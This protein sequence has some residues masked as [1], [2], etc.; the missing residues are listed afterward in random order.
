M[1][2]LVA[3]GASGKAASMQA[4]VDGLGARGVAASA[5]DLPLR[6]AEKAVP[7]YRERAADS[8]VAAADLVI[9]GQSYG[10]RVASL[11]AAEPPAVC[12]GLIC[13]SYPL[14]RPGQPDWDERSAHWPDIQVPLLFLSGASDP[15]A[16]LDLLQ[17]AIRERRPDA[18]LVTYPGVG[19]SLKSVLD[20]A[21]DAAAAFVAEVAGS[22]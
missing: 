16:R 6:K 11:L 4:H 2:V 22:P 3:H 20:A 19:H 17:R 15:F 10:G 9:S 18:R 14:H 13:F 12:A 21:L 8:G 7:V 1:H 5:V